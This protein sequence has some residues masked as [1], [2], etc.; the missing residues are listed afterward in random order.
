MTSLLGRFRFGRRT[1]KRILFNPFTLTTATIVLVVALFEIGSPIFETIELNWLDLR[2]RIRGP[3]TP[4]P[5]VVLATIDEKSLTD[6]GRWPWPRSKIAALVDALSRDGAKVIGFDITFAEPDEN[7]RLGFVNDLAK[8][9]ESRGLSDPQLTDFIQ[10]SRANA[11]NDQLLVN[12]LKR[13]KTPVVLGYFFHMSQMGVGYRLDQDD[14]DRRFS[15]IEAS[16]YPV[17]L[18]DGGDRSFIPF[19]EAYAPQNNLDILTDAAA[20]SGYFS[21]A[22]DPDGIVRWM[23]LM[24]KGG[25]DL[26]PSL[27]VL[28][29]W[30]FLGKPPLVVRTGKDGVEGLQIGE[31]FIPTDESGEMLINYRGPPRTFTHYP[32]SD[33]LGG[34]LAS[35]TFT[36]KIVIV[37]ATA[38]GIGDIRS[39]PFGPVY[40]GAEIHAS[41][42]DNILAGDF[43]ARPGWSKIFDLFA[44]VV[45][46][47]LVGVALPRMSA[48]EG[49]LFAGLLFVC[50][51]S[52]AYFLFVKAH[53]WLNMVYP[54]FALAATYTILT[55]YRYVTE[56]RER[57]RIKE[58]FKQYVAPDVI[59][60]VLKDPEDLRIGGQEKLLTVLFSDLAGFTAF[61]ERLSPNQV[62]EILGAYHD[63]MTEQLFAHQGTL[64]GYMGDELI[65]LFGA[66]VEQADQAQRACA[67]ALAMRDHRNALGDEWVKMGRPRLRARTGINSGTMLVGNIGSK[68]RFQYSVLGDPV[69][70]ASRLENISKVYGTEIIIGEQTA[71]LVEGFFTLRQLDLVRVV[72]RQQALKIFE[73]LGSPEKPLPQ[74]QE[75]MR[76]LY[77]TALDAY[78]QKRWTEALGLFSE[79]L[80]HWP[81]D[82]PSRI[83][84]ERCRIYIEIPP[85]DDWDGVF[86]H[87]TKK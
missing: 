53:V 77:A 52:A 62:I 67:T 4:T 38:I 10:E 34:K 41:V 17:V 46:S 56:E 61:S 70:L 28:C 71:H 85:P 65:A 43:I 63:L 49:L 33:I 58:T 51:V 20:S 3:L 5:D 19:F 80:V 31:R 42:I 86:E 75:R 78:Y 25:E 50:Y 18:Y 15:R 16:K 26:F 12:A 29:V 21:V 72:G 37:G 82:N 60:A 87:L 22:S 1:L 11:D 54:V 30:H 84:A 74:G 23:P 39:T 66:P 73:L 2:F 55:V 81:D 83:M 44:I 13:S 45:L 9:V 14:I 47:T 7:S 24:I 48:L 76:A 36:N 57:I 6:E 79:G 59:E 8:K 69:N 64:V 40:P 68:Y 27:S 35:G 32:I